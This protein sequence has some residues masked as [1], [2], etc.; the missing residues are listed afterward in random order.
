M[1]RVKLFYMHHLNRPVFAVF[2]NLVCMKNEL[3]SCNKF[4]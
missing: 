3:L 2:Q 1:D 4:G